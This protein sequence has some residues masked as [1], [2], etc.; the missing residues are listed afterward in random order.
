MH[1][2]EIDKYKKKHIFN[3]KSVLVSHIKKTLFLHILKS[4][5]SN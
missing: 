2:L 3:V 1:T 5:K 4:Q